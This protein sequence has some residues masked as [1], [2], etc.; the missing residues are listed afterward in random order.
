[1]VELEKALKLLLRSGELKKIRRTGWVLHN[2]PHPESVAEHSFRV[3]L[4]AFALADE[5]GADRNRMVK[6]ALIHDLG[7]S[8]IGDIPVGRADY[9]TKPAME[10]AAMKELSGL[11]ANRKEFLEL[12]D[13][14][15]T[16][17]TKEAQ[18][19]YELDKLEMVLQA[20]EY[21]REHSMDLQPFWDGVSEKI[22]TGEIRNKTLVEFYNLLDEKRKT[23]K[24]NKQSRHSSR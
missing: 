17:Q 23:F 22:R 7:E 15:E 6:M 1:M 10:T 2:V 3:A 8:V 11:F 14:Y 4:M 9:A 20:F 5:L 21:E 16:R 12:W 13:E 19:V 18:L 24:R